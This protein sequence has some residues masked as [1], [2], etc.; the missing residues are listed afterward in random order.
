MDKVARMK[1]DKYKQRR[2][3]AISK[4]LCPKCRNTAPVVGR[5][6][7]QKCLNAANKAAKECYKRLRKEVI[8]AYGGSCK[9]CGEDTFEFLVLDHVH[10][11]GASH[12]K[13]LKIG[14]GAANRSSTILNWAKKNRFP[15]ILQI[16]C[17]NCNMA[18]QCSGK[19]PH[20]SK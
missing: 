8:A 7:C 18:K 17:A 19:C 13:L 10:N 3:E 6:L 14:R 12:R 16:L 15:D 2:Q 1:P 5:Q 11:D 4:N 20:K 9:C